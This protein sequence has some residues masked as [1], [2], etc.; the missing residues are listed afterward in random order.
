MESHPVITPSWKTRILIG[1][2]GLTILVISLSATLSWAGDLLK[3]GSLQAESESYK[4]KNVRVEGLVTGHRINHFTG[5][6]MKRE[7]CIHYFTVRDDTG[8]MRAVY[9][10]ICPGGGALLRN[11]DRVTVDARFEKA[12]GTAGRLNVRSVVAK[13]VP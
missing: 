11:G 13:I 4:L 6:E 3:L 7:T 8:S 12:P 5:N 10:T 2:Q 9:M 1:W